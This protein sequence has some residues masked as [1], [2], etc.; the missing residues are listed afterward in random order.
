MSCAVDTETPSNPLRP[1]RA[2]LHPLWLAAL[3]LLAINDHVLKGS[4]LVPG[5]LTGKLSDV[6]G[7]LVAPTLLAVVLGVRTR[8]GWRGAHMVIGTVFSA[9]QLHAGA[10]SLWSA[11]MA[12][13]GV[14]WSIVCDPSDLLALPLLVVSARVFGRGMRR[15]A[16]SN[17]RRSGEWAAA[18]T[19]LAFCMATSPPPPEV[20]FREILADVY[21][22]NDGDA[23]LVVRARPLAESVDLDCD[24]VARDPGR[25]LQ[26]AVFGPG[27]AWSLRAH[28][29]MTL[30]EHEP[31]ER[32]C[33]AVLVDADNLAPAVVFWR[34]GQPPQQWVAGQDIDELGP[35]WIAIAFDQEGRGSWDSELEL[36]FPLLEDSPPAQGQCAGQPDTARLDWSAAPLGKHVLQSLEPGLDGCLAL[37]LENQQEIAEERWYL[38]VPTT[39]FP[40]TP[41]DDL[42]ITR[43]FHGSS[44]SVDGVRVSALDVQG[45]PAAV[46]R[47]LVLAR[48][49]GLPELFELDVAFTPDFDCGH[50][51]EPECGSVTRAGSITVGG[52][53]FGV[54]ETHGGEGP[55][56]LQAADGTRIDVMVAQ[57][58][59]RAVLD[60]ECAQG[61]DTLGP[62]IEIAAAYRGVG[63]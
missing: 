53:G 25:L 21:L 44:G 16:I 6:A 57:A 26:E 41:G 8:R 40:F 15:A 13:V 46:R 23:D 5:V 52:D 37:T 29:N 48:G 22:H 3:G 9:I 28:A 43:V 11:A 35:G 32:E 12:S 61:P 31:G 4:G 59:E 1:H 27:Q 14:P 7:L 38:C 49:S 63:G 10:A 33:Y 62:D 51:A 39:V 24:A 19:G 47:E 58:Q 60:P 56:T 50:V 54:V 20:V 2:L 18:M 34:D 55:V 36:F 30:L 45:D 17:L 42:E